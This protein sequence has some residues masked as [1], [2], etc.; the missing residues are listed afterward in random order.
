MSTKTIDQ[1]YPVVAASSSTE[2]TSLPANDAGNDDS[3]KKRSLSSS[4]PITTNESP[5]NKRRAIFSFDGDDEEVYEV[6]DDAPVWVPLMFK[7][8]DKLTQRMVDLYSKV[9]EVGAKFDTFKSDVNTQIADFKSEVNKKVED[10]ELAVDFIENDFESQK[11][12]IAKLKTELQN[13]IKAQG[14]SIDE[15]EQYSRRNCLLLHGVPES[16][17]EDTDALF[18]ST[19][20]EHLGTDVK[21][22]DID[23]THRLGPKRADGSSRPIIAKF[24][25][26]NVRASVFREKRKFKGTKFLLTESLTKTRVAILNAARDKHGKTNVWTSDGEILVSKDKKTVNVRNL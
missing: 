20:A 19:V 9:D 23:R 15:L 22:R 17:K 7:S 14:E 3:A 2:S 25:R 13:A 24:A 21:V 11:E 1:F 4:S 5:V 8:F 10:L 6:P 18:R 12:E 26:Y 16:D